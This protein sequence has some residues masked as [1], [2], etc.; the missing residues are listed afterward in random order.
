MAREDA[1][2]GGLI[3]PD[4]VVVRCR[5]YQA[6]ME[7]CDSDHKPVFSILDVEL[8][9]MKQEKKRKKTSDILKVHADVTHLNPCVEVNN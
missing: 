9:Y 7:V 2:A 3:T 6:L 8:P 5:R 4:E 1:V